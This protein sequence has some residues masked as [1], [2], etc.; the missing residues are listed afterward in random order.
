MTQTSYFH[1]D[2]AYWVIPDDDGFSVEVVS[3]E[4]HPTTVS[5]FATASEAKAW[6][7][8]E[9]RHCWHHGNLRY[10]VLG[11]PQ[12]ARVCCF[13]LPPAPDQG[14]LPRLC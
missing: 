12:L 7:A 14:R 8:T 2:L 3:S 10:R 13:L 5:P 9:S 6:V 4:N 11:H 1:T